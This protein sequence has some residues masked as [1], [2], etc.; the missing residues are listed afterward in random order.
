ML[1]KYKCKWCKQIFFGALQGLIEPAHPINHC[2]CCGH[3]D[4]EYLGDEDETSKCKELLL[5]VREVLDY[6]NL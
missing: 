5:R 3:P 1:G 6:Y 2:I 4:L